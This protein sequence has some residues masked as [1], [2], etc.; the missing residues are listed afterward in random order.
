MGFSFF[1]I[2]LDKTSF[3]PNNLSQNDTGFSTIV[4]LCSICEFPM[5]PISYGFLMPLRFFA[6]V[7]NTIGFMA[8][9]MHVKLG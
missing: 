6:L 8:M 1:S 4:F 9:L 7:D 5:P 2:G 3:P